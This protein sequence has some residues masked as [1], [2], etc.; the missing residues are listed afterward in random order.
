MT[1]ETQF[2]PESRF[3]GFTHV[4]GTIN[5]F[6]RIN[7]L[8]EPGSVVLDVGCGRGEYVDDPVKA[9]RDLRILRGKCAHVIGIDVDAGAGANRVVDEFRLI[10]GPVWPVADSSVDLCVCDHVIEHVSDP[11]G[12]LAECRRVIRAHS[13]LCIR[14]PNVFGYV[15]MIARLTPNG[16]HRKILHRV[17]GNRKEEDVFPTV[18]KCNT[19]RKLENMLSR[20]H[21]HSAVFTYDAEPR[22]LSFSKIAYRLGV[23]HQRYA[24]PMAKNV[25]F[26]FAQKQP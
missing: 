21:F 23:T 13:F 14:T 12:F 20:N 5:F 22:Y 8:L 11:Q 16:L 6:T 18:Y 9:R 10:E 2:Y 1:Y 7:A 17:Q 25:I 26:A 4:D 19:R 24:M 15:A 3:G